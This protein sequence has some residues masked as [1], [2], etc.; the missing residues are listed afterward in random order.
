MSPDLHHHTEATL[1]DDLQL[2]KGEDGQ[3]PCILRTW[4]QDSVELDLVGLSREEHRQPE[5]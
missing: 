5:C 4:Q 2:Q 1:H 3:L